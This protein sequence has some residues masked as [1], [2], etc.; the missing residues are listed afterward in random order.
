MSKTLLHRLF[1]FG[2]IPKRY[3][4]TL[5][6]EGIVLIDEGIGGS[7]TLKN[8]TAPGR[9]HSLK[10]SW[11]TGSLVLTEKTFAAFG[12]IRPL[13]YVPL[14]HERFSE[15]DYSV[16]DDNT[17]FIT[18]DPSAFDERSSGAIE[19]RFKTPK[20]RLFAECLAATA[21]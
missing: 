13:V 21:A 2:K 3:A 11:F 15:L 5:H 18:F 16:I 10:W 8:F 6:D 12:F 14:A 4:P 7:I 17:L 9:R 1:G 19:I 20:A